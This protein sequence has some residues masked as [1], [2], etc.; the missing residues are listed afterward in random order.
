MKRLLCLPA[1][2]IA[3]A[4]HAET[5]LSEVTGNWAGPAQNGFFY[6]AVLT[7]DEQ[8][9]RLRIYQGT[10]AD[11]IE[12]EPQFDNAKIAYVSGGVGGRGKDWL[13]VGAQGQLNLLSAATN[14]GYAYSERLTIQMMDNQFTAMA[15][16]LY[17][18]GPES[19]ASM[20][21]S[22]VGCWTADCYSCEADLWNGTAV[23]GGE[24]IPVPAAGF[25]ALN[26][27]DWTP[28]RVY[29]LGFCPAPN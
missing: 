5:V 9:L 18:N 12:T 4:A 1:L 3:G 6:R 11:R 23:A 29:E 25:E 27:S 24:Q 26:A 2:L 20:P 13:E 8:Y 15:Y 21:A 14:E 7:Q 16:G 28:E 22:P 19:V 17:N 10:S